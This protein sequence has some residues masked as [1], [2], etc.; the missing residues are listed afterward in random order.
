MPSIG[1]T[2]FLR[3]GFGEVHLFRGCVSMPS[4]GPTSFLQYFTYKIPEATTE[5]QCPPSG[6][7]HFYKLRKI[8]P[9][10]H[11]L[12]VNA[13]HRAYLISTLPSWNRL[14]KLLPS[15]VFARIF[16]NILKIISNNGK[17]WAEAGLYYFRYNSWGVLYNIII[18]YYIPI[19]TIGWETSQRTACGQ[20]LR[21]HLP[22][23]TRMHHFT[24]RGGLSP[25]TQYVLLQIQSL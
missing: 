24:H 15:F 7:P 8:E 25:A 14:F 16:R 23:G 1:P 6:L 18:S 20:T 21:Q 12:G 10:K 19:A 9:E 17:K 3:W 22:F 11:S 2:S 4:I 13:L 5:C